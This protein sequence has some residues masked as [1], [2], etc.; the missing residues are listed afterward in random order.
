MVICRDLFH[1]Q[2]TI[3]Q[4]Q[5]IYNVSQ[6]KSFAVLAKVSGYLEVR[7]YFSRLANGVRSAT[8]QQ[9]EELVLI[10]AANFV[11]VE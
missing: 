4:L 3:S 9:Q 1:M 2:A 8:A 7:G 11:M 5:L 6:Q 10:K